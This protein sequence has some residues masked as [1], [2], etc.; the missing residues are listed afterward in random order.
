MTTTK[1]LKDY[2]P[3]QFKVESIDLVVD[4]QE[5]AT[6]V[7]SSMKVKALGSAQELILNGEDL[8]LLSIKLDGIELGPKQFETSSETLTLYKVPAHFTLETTVEINPAANT[9][10]T[11][12]FMPNKN[13]CTQCEAEGFRRITYFFDRPDVLT[14]FTT[15]IIAD[16]NKFPI[17]LSNGN[18]IE[19]GEL[20]KNKHYTL[21]QDPFLKPCY[22][23]ALVG[24][25]FECAEDYFITR[26]GRKVTLQVY[27]EPGNL[28]KT[29]HAMQS[30]KQAMQ[31]DEKVFHREYD[32]DL[33][34]VVAV[35]DFNMGAM[36]NKGLNIFNSKYILVSPE[37][38]TDDDY[39]AVAAVIAHEY[40]HN[41]SG[42]RVTCRDWFQVSLKEGFT[43]F[44]DQEYTS[45]TTSRAVKRIKDVRALRNF[46]YPE[47]AG[48][49]AHPVQPD[50]YMEIDNFYTHTVYEKGAEVIRMMKLIIG[51]SAFYKGSDLYFQMNDGKAVTI[52]EFISA[53][54]Q[55]S[56][57]GLTQF[58]LWYHQ[59]GTPLI[60]LKSQFDSVRNV[61]IISTEQT[62]PATPGQMTALPMHIPLA[63][64]L[65]DDKGKRIQTKESQLLELKQ[66]KDTFTFSHVSTN[67]T[68][69][70]LNDFS[71]PVEL[72]YAYTKEELTF[73]MKHDQN[74]F[75]KCESM[76]VY[77]KELF[78]NSTKL[79]IEFFDAL[80]CSLDD[81]KLDYSFLA[82]LL[83]LPSEK[84]LL[85]LKKP[86]DPLLGHEKYK[87][88]EE[89]M[90]VYLF[91]RLK[92]WYLKL[93]PKNDYGKE[94]LAKRK[95]K[96][97]CLYYLSKLRTDE[98]TQ[99]LYQHYTTSNNMTDRLSAFKAMIAY[100]NP[101]KQD[102][103]NDFY[104]RFKNDLLVLD[105]WL[106]A[107]ALV[108]HENTLDTIK[109]LMQHHVFNIK[110][111]NKVKALIGAFSIY[112]MGQ[113][114]RQDGKGYALLADVVLELN[115]LNPQI[116]AKLLGPLIE[117][118]QFANPYQSLM[119]EQLDRIYAEPH[120]SGDVYE[121]ITKSI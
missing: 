107:Q 113:F 29:T 106:A 104:N 28:S 3:P 10:L 68:L 67:P 75:S 14:Q 44:R 12:L 2:V 112:N 8:R 56:G 87:L 98:V 4:L 40:F 53:M 85:T 63:I 88:L 38:A 99:I 16:K 92:Q 21:W 110:N 86:I 72:E 26:S 93:E 89:Q 105:K 1:Y 48:P 80:C 33:Y 11:G 43:I 27:V 49:M 52:E 59:A 51:D 96:N 23:F 62:I 118:R 82:E 115:Q 31:W 36:E 60:K 17:L 20:H 114:H 57:K 32:L 78:L 119:H 55:A 6:K 13:F 70:L 121:V 41:W 24:G 117:W 30:I 90:A 39:E 76:Q 109:D 103:I 100:E 84:Y 42:N 77:I 9:D 116:A 83:M 71:A 15:K 64:T 19:K 22:L 18:L 111:P 46:Q 69:S 66:H 50:S 74:P 5:S 94:T 65:Y 108:D 101:Y 79:P 58:R 95:L 54:E 35:N 97:V 37:T 120:L 45:D 73:L 102:C 61:L 81:S 34:M 91:E 47:D 7:T 25:I